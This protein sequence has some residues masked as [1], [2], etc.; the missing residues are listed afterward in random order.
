[1][2]RSWFVAAC[3]GPVGLLPPNRGEGETAS[4]L[5]PLGPGG[6]QFTWLPGTITVEVFLLKDVFVCVFVCKQISNQPTCL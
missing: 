1:M 6:V 5:G 4:V 3:S 2:G